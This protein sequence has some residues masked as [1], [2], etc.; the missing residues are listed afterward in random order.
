VLLE[1]EGKNGFFVMVITMSV[2]REEKERNQESLVVAFKTNHSSAS[3]HHQDK[4]RNGGA[5]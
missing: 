5:V 3:H 4:I 2:W 1:R